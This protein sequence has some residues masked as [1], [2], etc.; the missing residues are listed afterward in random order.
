M[1]NAIDH[2][3][4]AD[5]KDNIYPATWNEHFERW[6]GGNFQNDTTG[7]PLNESFEEEF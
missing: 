6:H 2:P 3:H 4:I 5:D 7:L 1:Y